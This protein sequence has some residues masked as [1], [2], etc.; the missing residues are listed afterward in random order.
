MISTTLATT[1]TTSTTLI[2][3]KS[4]VLFGVNAM[5]LIQ[6]INIPFEQQ[7]QNN[8]NNNNKNRVC[9]R[10]NFDLIMFNHPHLG[11]ID[12]RQQQQQIQKQKKQRCLM[13]YLLRNGMSNLLNLLLL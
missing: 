12:L 6:T 2:N 11:D 3:P 8:N 5:N 13:N 9:Y 7:Q 4:C 10:N 1:P